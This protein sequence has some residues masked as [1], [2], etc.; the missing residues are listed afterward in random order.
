MDDEK[1][2]RQLLSLLRDDREAEC[3]APNRAPVNWPEVLQRA[4]EFG[5]LPVLYLRAVAM[6]PP[7]R[8]PP[9]ALRRLRAAHL[10][11][12]ARNL[13]IAQDL[14]LILAA[15]RGADVPAIPLKGAHW[16][17]LIYA[18]PGQRAMG[19]LDLL[20]SAEALPRARQA[21]AAIGYAGADL[22]NGDHTHHERYVAPR[23]AAVLELH[24]RLDD[25]DSRAGPRD[26][27]GVWARARPAVLQGV[28]VLTLSPAD[29]LVYACLHIY[30]HG[31]RVG[32]RHIL[33]IAAI[34]EAAGDTL[35]WG[36]V[37]SL[38]GQ[39]RCARIVALLL[40]VARDWF[41]IALPQRAATL[42]AQQGA[43]THVAAAQ[44]VILGRYG[45][46]A[47]PDIVARLSGRR[48]LAEKA[49]VGLR[50]VLLP[51]RD[52]ARQH[53]IERRPP[54]MVCLCVRRLLHLTA[55][56]TIWLVAA[57]G[58]VRSLESDIRRRSTLLDWVEE[59]R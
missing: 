35:D 28:E 10:R 4:G 24:W 37:E 50:K 5:L 58:H 13:R 51:R 36:M 47:L 38:S 52:I 48:P 15:L 53:G 31:F 49:A 43:G 32:L 54:W 59:V 14:R 11:S 2:F 17:F 34:I 30:Y 29:Q 27:A 42:I 8:P 56:W 16:A 40:A 7:L 26:L 9:E 22:E 20:V 46:T 12:A 21:L 6:P 44:R 45:R 25:R 33:D 57:R 3:R 19:D 1:A 18:D 39:W 55:K 41:T 23:G